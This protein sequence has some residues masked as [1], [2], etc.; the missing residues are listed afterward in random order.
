MKADLPYVGGPITTGGEHQLLPI[1]KFAQNKYGIKEETHFE[2]VEN[3]V[4]EDDC[5]TLFGWKRMLLTEPL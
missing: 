4:N 2:F 3:D 5:K 1:K